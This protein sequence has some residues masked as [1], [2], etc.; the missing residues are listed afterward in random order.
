MT[1][2]Q[3]ADASKQ[4]ITKLLSVFEATDTNIV[5]D[6]Q[7]NVGFSC[8]SRGMKISGKVVVKE[9]SLDVVVNLPMIG[10]AFKGLVKAAMDKNIPKHLGN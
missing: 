6:G 4:A 1:K 2:E 10:I 5:S 9:D 7:D 8:T 3:A